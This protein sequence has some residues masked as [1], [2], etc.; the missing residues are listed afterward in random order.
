M[1]R[2]YEVRRAVAPDVFEA[3][4]KV[5]YGYREGVPQL[6]AITAQKPGTLYN[7]ADASDDS[8]NQPTLRDV[9]LVTQAT[10]D[11]RVLEALCEL[12]GRATY[13]TTRHAEVSDDALLDLLTKFGAENGDFHRALSQALTVKRFTDA[14]MATVRAEAMDVVGALMTL[15]HRL[16]GLVDD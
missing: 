5:V 10:N 8:H 6:A 15:L 1:K 7:K 2:N 14:E 9:V 11:M 12:F 3:F 4:R 13:D 16:E